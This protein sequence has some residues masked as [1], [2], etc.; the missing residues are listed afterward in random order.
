MPRNA[1]GTF[2]LVAGNPVVTGTVIESDWANTTMPDLGVEM[3]DS[4]SRSGKGGMLAA[5]KAVN[6]SNAA[7]SITFNSFLGQGLYSDSDGDVRMSVAQIDQMRWMNNSTQIWNAN[8]AEWFDVLTTRQTIIS[9]HQTETLSAGQTVVVFPDSIGGA[10]IVINGVN[11]DDG[12][13]LLG[14]DYT[15][16]AATKTSHLLTLTLRGLE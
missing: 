14:V 8:D 3:S 13:L 6:G 9:V 15:L 7:P 2:N 12:A 5:F 11:A 1:N 4:L 10:E 16:V